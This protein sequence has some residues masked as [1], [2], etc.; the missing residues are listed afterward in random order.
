MWQ[1]EPKEETQPSYGLADSLEDMASTFKA[2]GC[3]DF[4]GEEQQKHSIHPEGAAVNI[5][6]HIVNM[7][8]LKNLEKK[9]SMAE[10]QT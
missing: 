5:Q 4:Q 6:E 7:D 1:W 2:I 8:P 3:I 9:F 10:T